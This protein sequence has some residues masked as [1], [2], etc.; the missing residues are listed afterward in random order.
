IVAEAQCEELRVGMALRIYPSIGIARVGNDLT[1]FYVGPEIPGHNSKLRNPVTLPPGRAMLEMKPRP[2]GAT[3]FTNK[4][5]MVFVS[6]TSAVTAGVVIP[7]IRSG[8]RST[9]SLANL[10]ICS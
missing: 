4:I 3:M 8:L 9:S 7:R 1:K 5:G 2:S 6:C 10:R